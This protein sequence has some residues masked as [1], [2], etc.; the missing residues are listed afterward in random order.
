MGMTKS[1][2]LLL[3]VGTFILVSCSEEF[4]NPD[5]VIN[6]I[7]STKSIAEFVMTDD[8]TDSFTVAVNHAGLTKTLQSNGQFT[9]FVPNN[10]AFADLIS[11]LSS[12]NAIVEIDS[13][14]LA[15]LLRYH[16]LDAI[17][18]SDS[19]NDDS[20]GKTLNTA[21]PNNENTVLEIDVSGGFM[22]N[23]TALVIEENLRM[24]NGIVH[25]IDQILMPTNILGML[26]N[27]ERFSTLLQALQVFGDT[28]TD[29]LTLR[30][31]MTIF[32]PTN[33]AF[34]NLLSTN[35]WSNINDI[36]RLVL[37][38][39]LAY[40]LSPNVNLQSSQ[41]T[42]GLSISTL[43]DSSLSVD[44]SSGIQLI[45]SSTNQGN[46]NFATTDIQCTNG[47]IHAIEEVLLLE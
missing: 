7:D 9:V 40:H 30:G 28:L 45:T 12:A 29:T 2:F 44:L 36:P 14:A 39:V 37:K 18:I 27:D 26:N 20:Y 34:A 41:L 5:P 43:A 46:I 24:T 8:E 19:L 4:E 42:Q 1:L 31:P 17:L 32:A 23:N 16:I 3:I 25:T 10:K 22:I 33:D 11:M 35:G 15:Q 13:N 38:D 6:S 21:N 47:I